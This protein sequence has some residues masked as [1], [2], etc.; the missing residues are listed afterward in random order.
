MAY[1]RALCVPRGFHHFP[2]KDDEDDALLKMNL[3]ESLERF[4]QDRTKL[5]ER[6]KQLS[7]D[8]WQRTAEHGEY[9]HYSVFIMFRPLAMR[10]MLHAYRI[11]E[12]C[13]GASCAAREVGLTAPCLVLVALLS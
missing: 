3:H 10:D 11:E 7:A 6:L 2:D 13:C 8:D 1:P 9:S 4:A 5:V 12:L